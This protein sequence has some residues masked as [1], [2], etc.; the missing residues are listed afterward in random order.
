DAE[1][2]LG[3]RGG[4]GVRPAEPIVAAGPDHRRRE[5]REAGDTIPLLAVQ[6]RLVALAAAEE[7]DVRVLEEQRVSRGGP[8]G[9]D[10]P[11]VRALIGAGVGLAGTDR[12]ALP[13]RQ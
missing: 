6:M 1:R 8:R 11:R 7:G 5:D 12:R 10:R 13:F 2:V 9:R 3:I 4:I